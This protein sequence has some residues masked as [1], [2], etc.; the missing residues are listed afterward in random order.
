MENDP[1]YSKCCI[2]GLSKNAIKIDWHHNLI[3]AGRQVNE[4][5]CILP[6]ADWVHRNIVK[7]KQKCDWIMLNRAS[8]EELQRY[9][10]AK[11]YFKEKERL[12]K[13]YGK[14]NK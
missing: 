5:F 4:K 1:F 11:D 8:D 2:T 6:L 10:K 13:I 3:Y 9:S 14:Y 7:Y 12:N